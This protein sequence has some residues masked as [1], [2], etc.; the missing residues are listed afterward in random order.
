MVDHIELA[1][2]QWMF[3]F[4]TLTLLLSTSTYCQVE[5]VVYPR[6][7][8]NTQEPEG[9]IWDHDKHIL[10]WSHC[11]FPHPGYDAQGCGRISNRTWTYSLC[12]PGR[13]LTRD[14]GNYD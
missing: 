11:R 2:R 8:V 5:Q 1:A 7:H 6:C 10:Y 9:S 13:Q 4:I 12:D 3:I 14:E